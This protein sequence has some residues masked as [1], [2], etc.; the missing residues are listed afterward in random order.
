MQEQVLLK[1]YKLIIEMLNFFFLEFP[2]KFH[3]FFNSDFWASSCVWICF[4]TFDILKTCIL[5]TYYCFTSGSFSKEVVVHETDIHFI[6][7]FFLKIQTSI[8]IFGDFFFVK[9]FW[10]NSRN[11]ILCF[12][13]EFQNVPGILKHIL[14]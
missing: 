9:K 1:S 12:N 3:Y 10:Y 7:V 6:P 11:S 2:S 8:P 13:Y 5:L 14:I 4:L